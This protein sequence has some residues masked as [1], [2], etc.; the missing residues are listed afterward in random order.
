MC[1]KSDMTNASRRNFSELSVQLTSI[2]NE[3]KSIVMILFYIFLFVYLSIFDRNVL[4][5][6]GLE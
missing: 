6:V 5:G 2:R 1:L 4:Y 3:K